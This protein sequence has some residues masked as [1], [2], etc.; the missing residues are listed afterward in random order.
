MVQQIGGD[1]LVVVVG[2][3]GKRSSPVAITEGVEA[4]HIGLELIIHL[5]VTA[6][7]HRDAGVFQ[8]KVIRGSARGR[9][10]EANA[11]Q[12]LSYR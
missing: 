2:R 1:D 5:Y 3:V 4:R 8:T 9:L 7:I 6:L 11:S 10:R 12:G